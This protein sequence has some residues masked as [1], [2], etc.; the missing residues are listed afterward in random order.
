MFSLR[1]WRLLGAL[2]LVA[3]LGACAHPISLE[4][5]STPPRDES[6]LLAKKVAYV[7][8]DEQR[9]RQVITAGGGGDKVSYYPYRDMEKSF[10]DALRSVYADVVV[11]RSASDG[12][13]IAAA[14]ASFVFAPEI[15][16]ETH[17]PSLLTW[18]P[19]RFDT[20]LQCQV[21]D[22]NGV[23]LAAVNVNASGVAEFDEFKSDFSLSARRSVQAVMAKFVEELRKIDKLK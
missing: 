23:A 22:A 5:R 8:N 6:A 11:V 9:G 4:P 13:A 19:T 12:A 2:S 18:P 10:R 1:G 17:S 7:M 15:R 3:L 20:M 16:T 21:S 14:G